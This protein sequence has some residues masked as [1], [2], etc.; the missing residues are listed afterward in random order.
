MVRL[1]GEIPTEFLRHAVDF[2]ND[3]LLGTLGA[4]LIVHP[5]TEKDHRAAVE[6]ALDGLRYGTL[7]VNCW[8]A[9][10][11]LLGYTPLGGLPGQHP[12]GHRQRHR[13]RPQR[14]HAR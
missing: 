2:A 11:F 5:R 12:A 9:V 7:G 1:P 4:T 14:L 10:G 3:T 13:L 8:S 6:A